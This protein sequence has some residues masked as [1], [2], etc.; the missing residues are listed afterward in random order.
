MTALKDQ[1]ET[2]AGAVQKLSKR[3]D[4][5]TLL[6]L[7]SFYKQATVGNVSGSR[8]GF[9]DFVGRAKHDAWAELKGTVKD[10]AMRAYIALV[11][12]LRRSDG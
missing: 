9:I 12:K 7:Y 1:F 2:A 4:D 10:D 3:P 11:T 8:P 6:K 5:A